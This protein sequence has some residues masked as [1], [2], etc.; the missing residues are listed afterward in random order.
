MKSLNEQLNPEVLIDVVEGQLPIESLFSNKQG[1]N[2]DPAIEEKIAYLR[3][4]LSFLDAHHVSSTFKATSE[5]LIRII[6]QKLSQQVDDIS[7]IYDLPD[8]ILGDIDTDR[9]RRIEEA[10]A[11]DPELQKNYEEILS[12]VKTVDPKTVKYVFDRNARVLSY[13]VTQKRKQREPAPLFL[14]Q[15]FSRWKGITVALGVLLVSL[16]IF[17]S[18][19]L[20]HRQSVVSEFTIE[21]DQNIE[22]FLLVP[23]IYADVWFEQELTT[24]EIESIIQSD[25]EFIGIQEESLEQVDIFAVPEKYGIQEFEQ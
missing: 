1:I 24:Q 17:L 25:F 12:I 20:L 14:M 5:H 22:N 6:P 11:H 16:A 21:D 3:N 7:I 15:L 9:K 4:I 2:P 8:Y 10:L 19:L 13:T 23:A 18:P